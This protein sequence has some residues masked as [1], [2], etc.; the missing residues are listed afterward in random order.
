MQKEIIHNWLLSTENGLQFKECLE[1]G[2]NNTIEYH[3]D[4]LN[5]DIV[6]CK[7]CKAKH[8]ITALY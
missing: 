5:G 8:E 7:E 6:K 2:Y 3:F 1:C 4:C